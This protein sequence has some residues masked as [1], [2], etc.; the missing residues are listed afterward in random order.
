MS[1]N[2]VRYM[3]VA[4]L[5]EDKSYSIECIDLS[6]V[7]FI[8]TDRN[9]KVVFHIGVHQY[10]HLTTKSDFDNLLLHEGFDIL[11]RPNLV[12]LRK[13]R[14]FCEEYGKVY[15]EENPTSS[16][17]YVTVARIKYKFVSSLLKRV[18][19]HTINPSTEIKEPSFKNK[20]KEFFP[21]ND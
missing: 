16:S 20:L 3:T 13:A 18:N 4:K 8:T 19:P 12:N 14:S 1:N 21:L 15:F 7:D 11:D 5:H 10:C 17:K 2:P 6:D 9:R